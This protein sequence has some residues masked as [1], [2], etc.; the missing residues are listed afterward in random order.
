MNSAIMI[1][2]TIR[3]GNS[4]SSLNDNTSNHHATLNGSNSSPSNSITIMSSPALPFLDE[5]LL[6]TLLPIVLLFRVI[7]PLRLSVVVC[8]ILP[9]LFHDH[10]YVRLFLPPSE[11]LVVLVIRVPFED[12]VVVLRVVSLIFFVLRL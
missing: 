2:M 12:C 6:R 1:P 9:F 3:Y 8:R 7:Q 10:E 5:R 11:P 4:N